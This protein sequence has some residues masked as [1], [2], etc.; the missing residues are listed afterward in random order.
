MGRSGDGARRGSPVHPG[1]DEGPGLDESCL[2][3]PRSGENLFKPN[4][5]GIF[6]IKQFV[7]DVAFL[8]TSRD[9]SVSR[10]A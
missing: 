10:C 9:A 8:R 4:G 6:L 1:V 7:D 5:R 2:R 3:D